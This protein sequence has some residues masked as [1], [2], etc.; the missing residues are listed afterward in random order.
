[1][2]ISNSHVCL[3]ILQGITWRR[4]RIG[5]VPSNPDDAATYICMNTIL[6]GISSNPETGFSEH[7]KLFLAFLYDAFLNS[8][9]H[10][11]LCG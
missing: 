9:S 5:L 6:A 7:K 8:E 11:E 10:I 2:L 3:S 1:M 4:C